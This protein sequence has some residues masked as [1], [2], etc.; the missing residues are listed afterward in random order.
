MSPY[1]CIKSYSL[2]GTEQVTLPVKAFSWLHDVFELL[3]IEGTKNVS[4]LSVS[5]SNTLFESCT[6]FRKP[7]AS[8]SFCFHSA[9]VWA[10]SAKTVYSPPKRPL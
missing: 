10:D 7:M 4:E 6:T 2:K 1:D 8:S 9:R 5:I 3:M